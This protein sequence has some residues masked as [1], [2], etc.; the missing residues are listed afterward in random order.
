MKIDEIFQKIR[1]F[2]KV[3]KMAIFRYFAEGLIRQ[4]CEKWPN[5][6]VN[7]KSLKS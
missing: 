2:A 6:W 3:V 4:K 1:R 5:F 7:L